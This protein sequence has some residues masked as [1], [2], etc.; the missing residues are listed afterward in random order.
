MIRSLYFNDN[1]SEVMT[2]LTP[3]Q[4]RAA[5]ENPYGLLWVSIETTTPQEADQILNNVFDFH[6]LAVED[7]LSP[8][9][10]V[11][12]VDDFD[13]YLFVTVHGIVPRLTLEEFDTEELNLFI[14]ENYLVTSF[15]DETFPSINT[16]WERA[17]K[18]ERLLCRGSDFLAYAIMDAMVDE[19]LPIIDTIDDE[20]EM[21]EDMVLVNPRPV[22]LDRILTLKHSLVTLRRVMSPQREVMNRLSRDD[23]QLIDR[24]ARI[25][26][27]DIYDHLVRFQDFVETLRDLVSDTMSTYLSASSNRM[28]E[29]MKA[30]TI[31]STIFLP[32]SFVAGVYGMNFHFM[33]ELS[34]PWGYPLVWVVF[35]MIAAGMLLYFKKRGWF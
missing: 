2:D 6:P 7:C 17:F 23:F 34:S 8:G 16:A 1:N 27:R 13:S 25:Y 24:Q 15:L 4:M 35:I 26:F 31:V 20:I 33:P 14:G 28:N 29:I 19:Y 22:I 10:Q 5:L 21:L 9:Y 12:K 18:D 30:L 3:E 11:P 32:L